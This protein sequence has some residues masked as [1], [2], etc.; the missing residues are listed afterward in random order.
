[1][2]PGPTAD[3]GAETDDIAV[4]FY[5]MLPYTEAIKPVDANKNA[6]GE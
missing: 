1:M 2:Q 3:F 6:S 4:C 5:S